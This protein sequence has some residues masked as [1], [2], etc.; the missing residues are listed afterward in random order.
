[1]LK[2][3]T[4]GVPAFEPLTEIEYD[5]LRV[6]AYMD[7]FREL[8]KGQPRAF[9]A[10]RAL[11]SQFPDDALVQLHWHRLQRGELGSTI[12]LAEK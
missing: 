12:V 6:T 7:A 3:K 1:V 5:S 8:D 9:D 4:R 10:F 11:S 2:G